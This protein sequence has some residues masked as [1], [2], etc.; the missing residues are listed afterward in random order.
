[1]AVAI[2]EDSVFFSYENKKMLSRW[3][4]TDN[5]KIIVAGLE[6]EVIKCLSNSFLFERLSSQ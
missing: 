2:F 5:I 1:M 3:D 6:T 4:D